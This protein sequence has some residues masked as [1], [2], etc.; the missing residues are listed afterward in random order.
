ME[1][2]KP[3]RDKDVQKSGSHS[4]RRRKKGNPFAEFLQLYGKYIILALI[5][6]VVVVAVILIVGRM[7]NSDQDGTTEAESSTAAESLPG[8][9]LEQNANPEVNA[10]INSYI[11][12]V[13]D[14]DIDALSTLVATTE[15]I[16]LEQLQAERE[17]MESYQNIVCYTLD[18]LLDGTYITYVSYDLKFLNVD[19]PAPCMVRFYICTNEDGSLYINNDSIDEEVMNYMDQVQAREDVQALLNETDEKLV[20]ARASDE[21]LNALVLRMNGTDSTDASDE[22]ESQT[23]AAETTQAPEETTAESSTAAETTA[24]AD[25]S[26]FTEVDET[27]YARE[28]VRVRR[29][30]DANGEVVGTLAGGQ[31]VH[32]TGYND[33]WSRVE[34]NGET[35][36]IAAG[37]LTANAPESQTAASDDFTSVDETVYATA[38]VRVRSTPDA[39]G[40]V[41]GTLVGGDSVR[42]TGYNDSWSRVEFNGQTGYIAAGYLTYNAPAGDE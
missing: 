37:Y 34:F 18:G 9:P 33:S 7:R 14:C 5:A 41:I 17:F 19:T 35:C 20:E 3:R 26:T 27:V 32:R 23:T 28:N 30:P 39:D 36:Y 22:S 11:T 8:G 38:N 21:A 13:H 40:E 15:S 29:T 24:S 31:S 25:N 12:A 4:R 1:E 16:S 6:V 42:R 2:L 10:L